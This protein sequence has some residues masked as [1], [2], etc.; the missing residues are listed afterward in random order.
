MVLE[1]LNNEAEITGFVIEGY[2]DVKA[3]ISRDPDE[4]YYSITA[5]LPYGAALTSLKPLIQYKGETLDPAS[6]VV[7]D[8]SVPVF[9]KVTA[10]DKTTVKNYKVILNNEAAD[11]DTG[12]FDFVITNVPRN[13]VVIGQNPRQD[14]KIPIVVQVPYGTDERNM[15]PAITLRSSRS[16][17]SPA[18]GQVIPFVNQEA[19]YTVTAEDKVTTRQYVVVVSQG[20]QYYY[21]DGENGDDTWPDYYNGGSEFYPFKTLAYAVQKAAADGIDKI[22]VKVELNSFNQTGPGAAPS[23]D[24]G[25]VIAI[26]GSDD[27]EITVTGLSGG[28]VL[29]GTAGQRAVSVTGG[30][31]IVF[32]NITV[33]GGNAPAS[34]NNGKGGGIYISGN[35]KVKFSGGA[36]TGNTARLGGGVFVEDSGSNNSEFTLMGGTISDNKAT[37]STMSVSSDTDPL[38]GG[39]GVYVNGN[40]LFWLAD[41]TIRGNTAPGGSGAGVLV[42]GT[43][44]GYGPQDENSGFIMSGGTIANNVSSGSKSP[45]GG[46]G[47]YVAR[48]EFD[49]LGGSITGNTSVRQGGGVFVR[50]GAVFN[51]SGS[52]SIAGNSGV[53]SSK[54]ICSRGITEMTGNAQADTI[55][56]WNPLAED[57][58]IS[59]NGFTL[60]GNARAR[61]IVLA[62]SAEYRNYVW[63]TRIEGTDQ[64][65]TIDLEGHLTP[66]S[67]A[68]ID[69]ELEKDW[70][71]QSLLK[72]AV[73][74]NMAARFPLGAFVGG[75][76]LPLSPY[77]IDASGKL[78]KK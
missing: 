66:P 56:V 17:I 63:L 58:G 10:Y 5:T 19:V 15:I 44:E 33:T 25:S 29:R 22:W 40:A 68:F 32:E 45:H 77:K 48:G 69:T 60:S 21:V 71:N 49:M 9:Y 53:G 35:S 4:G 57:G 36:V 41:G 23:T 18:S 13:K 70:L 7:R 61:A 76:T 50:T 14:G 12:I 8:F 59:E 31:D 20:P 51:A 34:S 62:H 3:D 47:V 46:G 24:A 52:S 43:L 39:G 38:G 1:A 27:K 54:G 64:L 6:G 42:R 65:A 30:A 2:P 55:Y 16:T 37:A 67:Y 74:A 75:R 78:V 72:G 28:A 11:Q 26:N 73:D